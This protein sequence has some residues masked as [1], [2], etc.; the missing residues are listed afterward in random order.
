[1]LHFVVFA[2][3]FLFAGCEPQPPINKI[4]G[5]TMGTTWSVQIAETNFTQQSLITSK[6]KDKLIAINN[7]FSTYQTNSRISQFN[8]HRSTT[9]FKVS[10][11]FFKVAQ[12]A[13]DISQLTHG[14]F[15]PT[16]APLID[17]WG[18]GKDIKTALPTDE[19]IASTQLLTGYYQLILDTGNTTLQKKHPKLRIDYSAIAKGYAV[20]V[21]SDLLLQEGFTNHLVEIGG[22]LKA[23]GTKSENRPWTVAIANPATGTP[24]AM[25]TIPLDNASIATSGN[26]NNFFVF[27]G[28]RYNHTLDPLTARPVTHTL[29]SVTV[30]HESA[31]V[32]DALATALMVMGVNEGITFANKHKLKVFMVNQEGQTLTSYR[33]NDFSDE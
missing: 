16:L 26:Y 30:Q 10:D 17:L 33:S 1:M 4:S 2:L 24:S 20:D 6:I 12:A 9:P 7:E 13:A 11:E 3:L 28:K 32:A 29:A 31:M 18:F 5:A 27:A 23:S 8:Q 14:A 19:D 22:E 25:Q 21:I 15:D